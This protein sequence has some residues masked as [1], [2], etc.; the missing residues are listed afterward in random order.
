MASS[1]Y[2]PKIQAHVEWLKSNFKDSLANYEKNAT[3][4]KHLS[5]LQNKTAYTSLAHLDITID[6]WL[7]CG[8]PKLVV[9]V[10]TFPSILPL[11]EILANWGCDFNRS[12]DSATYNTRSY[13]SD[14]VCVE[15][16]LQ[17]GDETCKRVIIGY[18]EPEPPRPKYA[19]QCGDALP[20]PSVTIGG[21]PPDDI[22][23]ESQGVTDETQ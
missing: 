9:D 18:H 20:V 2:P 14:K 3:M 21:R 4:F 22:A 1:K 6:D 12:H 5:Y 8:K 7:F 23:D 11:L 16:H 19:F 15:A 10:K 17:E 13:Y